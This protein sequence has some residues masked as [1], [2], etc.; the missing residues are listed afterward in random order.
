MKGALFSMA[1]ALEDEVI[2]PPRG[3]EGEWG[4]A[5]TKPMVA[6]TVNTVVTFISVT[7]CC[8]L[9]VCGGGGGAERP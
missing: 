3:M 4:P 8:L 2:D 5:W 6:R 1:W 7:V 9:C